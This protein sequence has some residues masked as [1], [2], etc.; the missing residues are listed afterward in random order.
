MWP[1]TG[2]T[3]TIPD[4]L[5]AVCYTNKS[6]RPKISHSSA[7]SAKEN[8]D[9][10]IYSVQL[11]ADEPEKNISILNTFLEE[12]KEV[13]AGIIFNSRAHLLGKYFRDKGEKFRL[14]GYD[15]IDPNIT[16]LNDGSIT[17]LIAQRPEVQGFNCIRALFRHLVLKEKVEQ[18]NYMPIDILMK[19]N[20]K[21]YNNYI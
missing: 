14:I 8:Y 12:H 13:N 5:P 11:H 3:R 1:I 2:L 9:G 4:T 18:I 7:L 19:E 17:H 10:R 16:C 20:I 6:T 21:Y 15:V